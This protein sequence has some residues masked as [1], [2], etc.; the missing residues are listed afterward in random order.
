MTLIAFAFLLASLPTGEEWQNNQLLSAGREATR[1]SFSSFDTEQ[2]A[3][4]ILP[5]F[6]ERTVSLDS[7]TAW[8]FN[9]AK[10]PSSRPVG[11]EDP[12]YDVSEWPSI[13]VPCSWQ[14][15]GA[16]GKGGWG[17]ALYTNIRYP[18]ARDVPGGSKVMGEPPRHYTNFDARNPV[19]SYR[20]DF[21]LPKTWPAEGDVFLKFDGVDSFFY[22]WVNGEYV[23]FSKDSRAPAEFDVTKFVKRGKNTVALEVYRYS[24]GSYL[25]DQDMFR[26]SGIFRRTWLLSRPKS[27]I[28]DFRVTARPA[29]KDCFAGA[30]EMEVKAEGSAREWTVAVYSFDDRIVASKKYTSAP[31]GLNPALLLKIP[32]VK[33][34]SAEEPNCYKVVLGNGEEYVSTVFGFRVSEMRTEPSGVSRYYL[35]GK[36]IKLKGANRHETDPMYGHYVPRERH[37]Q[38]V[39]QLKEANCNAVRNSHYPQ[40]DYW[41]Y[42]CDVNGIYLVDE[43]N[44][45]SHG[46]GYGNDS[47]SHQKSWEKATVDRNLSMVK[48]NFNHPSVIIW[49]LGNEAG[50]GE[51]FQ[52]ANAAIKALDPVRPIHYERDWSVADMDGCQYPAVPWVW[53]KAA[54]KHS[55]KPFYI[56]EYAHNMVNA[57]GNLKDYQDAIESSD[58]ILGATIWDWVDQGLYKDKDGTRIIAFGGDFGD[59]PND[60]Q[61][62]MNGCVL[63]DRTPEPGYW[64]IKH[65][66]QNWTARATN[67]FRQVVLRNKNHFVDSTGVVCK[68]VLLRNGSPYAGDAFP[69]EKSVKD[70]FGRELRKV[71]V[72]PQEEIVVDMPKVLGEA[73]EKE[74]VFALR[75]KFFKGKDEIAADQIDFPVGVREQLAD[76]RRARIA[77]PR[78]KEDEKAISFQVPG[79]VIAFCRKTGLPC[80]IAVGGLFADKELLRAP[81]K[82]DVFRTPSSNEVGLGC[83]WVENGL[84]D[85]E[86]V[87]AEL[88][89]V[90]TEGGECR[91]TALVTWKGREPKRLDGF[92]GTAIRLVK[93][94]EQRRPLTFV[95][96][97][98]WRVQGDGTVVC[99]AKVR[100]MGPRLELAR[101]G[102]SL[103]LNERNADISWLGRGP[104]E[105]YRDRKSGA[106][107]GLWRATASDFFFP[108]ARNENCGNRE[109]A[110]GV[111]VGALTFRTLGAPF[112]F[113]ANPYTSAELLQY[114]H[115]AELPKSDKTVF[116][117]YSET[118]GLGGASCGPGPLHADVIRTDRDYALDFTLRL[119]DWSLAP[120]AAGEARLPELPAQADGSEARIVACSSREPGEGEAEHLLDGDLSTI[121]HSQYGTTMGSF[122]YVVTVELKDAAVLKGLNVWQR[123]TGINGQVRDYIVEVSADGKSW[124]EAAKGALERHQNA[125]AILFKAP[126]EARLFRFSALNN[127][128]GNDFASLAEIEI[129]K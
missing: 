94:P 41:Y 31:S 68:W 81:M 78:V 63:S 45:E 44:V 100:A 33:P 54:E 5:E 22:L 117:I 12:D 118:R 80:S 112:A 14:A 123:Q 55:Q 115:P 61:F 27:R 119:D 70:E 59:Q 92:G 13:K 26:L 50:P 106:F 43:A 82:L 56:S 4:R 79:G 1:A 90:E 24:D 36:K 49:S 11:F 110:Y 28:R 107:V 67:D 96:A 84:D 102:L 87:S 8:K 89:P 120:R 122:P 38:D 104:F 23:G 128:H 129:I 98:E 25:E 76:L 85:L 126:V 52:A 48:R 17:T 111:K 121:W 15:Y 99:R 40:D 127:H 77:P 30:W 74:G 9:W 101:V 47:L 114:V 93:I 65:V 95:M 21:I 108:Y 3:L 42:L 124:S 39:K 20:R 91:F 37:E 125:Q 7:D 35:N 51:N 83:K 71:P 62:V 6:S 29:M 86:A 88:S 18:F 34:W 66:Y 10:D 103:T 73:L 57:M 116:G 64:E 2:S 109:D 32:D 75:V 60:G 19:G 16:N 46:Y 58:V 113:E 105:N 72:P 53:A 69:L 97:T